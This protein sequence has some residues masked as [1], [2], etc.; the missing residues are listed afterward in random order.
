MKIKLFV[1]TI[2]LTFCASLS[3]LFGN[4]SLTSTEERP[5]RPTEI[6]GPED[7]PLAL[8]LGNG[9]AGPT[10]V[11][12]ELSEDFINTYNCNIRIGWIQTITRL[13]LENLKEKVIDISL[14]YESVPEQEAIEEGWASNRALIFNDHFILVGPKSNPAYISPTDTIEE[15]FQKIALSGSLYFSRDD[16]SGSNAREREVW[17]SIQ[18]CPW[19]ERP[20]WYIAKKVF[21]ADALEISDRGEMYTLTDRGTLIANRSGLSRTGVYIQKG[22]NLMNRCHAMLQNDPSDL[23]LQFLEYL[24]SDRAQEIIDTYAGKKLKNCSDCCPLFTSARHDDFLKAD[25]LEKLGFE[26]AYF[27]K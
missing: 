19:E 14:T 3:P 9:G 23:A 13:T 21:P 4:E 10:C 26:P 17:S 2:F 6:Y 7:A 18:E 12:Q 11:L 27:E 8:I 16:F 5:V 20:E 25:C 15:A 1:F 24:T 22:P